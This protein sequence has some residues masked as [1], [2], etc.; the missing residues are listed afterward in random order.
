V[1][2]GPVVPGPGAAPAAGP[3]GG[4]GAPGASPADATV[5]DANGAETKLGAEAASVSREPSGIT[6]DVQ[7]AKSFSVGQ[8]RTVESAGPD[9]VK[10]TVRIVGPAL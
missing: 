10:R 6:G 3:D 5:L 2:A 8:G 1:V 4:P 7:A 9:G